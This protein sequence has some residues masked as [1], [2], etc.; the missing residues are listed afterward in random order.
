MRPEQ[1]EHF[2]KLLEKQQKELSETSDAANEASQTVVLDQA[3]VGRLSRMDAMQGQ[4][5][6]LENK[7][8]R[9]LQHKRIASALRRIDSDNFGYCIDCD[10]E[11]SQGRLESDPANSLCIDCASKRDK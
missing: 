11:I 2:R 8:R 1:I 6:A 10:E 3:S 4:A 7:R 9:E 5:M